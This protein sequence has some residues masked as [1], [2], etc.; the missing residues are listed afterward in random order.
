MITIDS[1]HRVAPACQRIRVGI[2]VRN[3]STNHDIRLVSLDEIVRASPR[4][5]QKHS[6]ILDD[7]DRNDPNS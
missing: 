1:G 5:Y 3:I 4:R 7:T 6:S 2:G